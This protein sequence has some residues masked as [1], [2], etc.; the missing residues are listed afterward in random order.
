[1]F[2]RLCAFRSRVA[3]VK[4]MEVVGIYSQEEMELARAGG[5]SF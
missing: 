3:A 1:V 5:G 2:C 4:Y